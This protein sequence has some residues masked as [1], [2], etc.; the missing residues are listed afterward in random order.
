MRTFIHVWIFLLVSKRKMIFFAADGFV[1][2]L[3]L[4]VNWFKWLE[5]LLSL[6]DSGSSYLQQ[7]CACVLNVVVSPFVLHTIAWESAHYLAS[8]NHTPIQANLRS[9]VLSPIVQKC[10]QMYIQCIHQRMYHVTQPEYDD[11]ISVVQSAQKAFVMAPGGM[12]QF[13]DFLQSLRRLSPLKRELWTRLAST[14]SPGNV[15]EHSSSSHW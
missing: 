5:W 13:N 14:L 1:C 7:F 8:N 2:L 6:C 15:F 4:L 3:V 12:A 10:V 11:F 9:L